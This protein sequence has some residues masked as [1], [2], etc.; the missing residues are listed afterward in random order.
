MNSD[1]NIGSQNFLSNGGYDFFILKLSSQ[2]DL[3][4][5]KNYGNS[6][7]LYAYGSSITISNDKIIF[8][9]EYS[10]SGLTSLAIEDTTISLGNEEFGNNLMI[11]LKRSSRY[12]FDVV[13]M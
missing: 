6:D 9:G 2:G 1:F 3:I 7:I 5:F 12:L 11:S 13:K 4:W 10:S 8:T